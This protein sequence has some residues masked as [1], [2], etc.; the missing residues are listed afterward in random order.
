MGP[1]RAEPKSETTKTRKAKRPFGCGWTIGDGVGTVG[2][3]GECAGSD[4]KSRC[5]GECASWRISRPHPTKP[6]LASV[7][8]S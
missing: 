8:R 7:S 2:S 6:I 4:G 5:V 1:M 3:E